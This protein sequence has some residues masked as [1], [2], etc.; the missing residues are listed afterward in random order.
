MHYVK[1]CV[2]IFDKRKCISMNDT[3][4]HRYSWGGL[5]Q[6][7]YITLLFPTNV[8]NQHLRLFFITPNHTP[9]SFS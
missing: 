5:K 1:Q 7:D 3:F 2:I 8:Y 4:V 6:C 9:I